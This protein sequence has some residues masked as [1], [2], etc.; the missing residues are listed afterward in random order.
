MASFSRTGIT[1]DT[2]YSGTVNA[3]VCGSAGGAWTLSGCELDC[4]QPTS[5]TGYNFS[6]A[7]TGSLAK[8]G[9]ARDGVTCATGYSG[10]VTETACTTGGQDYTVA[11]CDADCTQPSTG[12]YN[13]TNVAGSKAKNGF[14][15]TGITC[16]SGYSG[17][18]VAAVC[19]TGGNAYTVTGCTADTCKS[20]LAGY[21][22]SS[23]TGSIATGSFAVTGVQCASGYAGVPIATV[24]ASANAPYV[25]SGCVDTCVRPTTTG[26]DFS[27]VSETDLSADGTF[28]VTGITC[29]SGY[30]GTAVATVCSSS[31]KYVVSGCTVIPAT[32]TLRATTTGAPSTTTAAPV[33]ALAKTDA[34]SNITPN[35]LSIVVAFIAL[36]IM[37]N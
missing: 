16:A 27:S 35:M 8:T 37:H 31:D 7:D 15:I 28:D 18:A 14:S 25:L 24:C 9:F 29:A 22:L 6:T 21:D 1:C 30:Q 20:P 12:G 5:E 23:A 26:Y 2:G 17:T 32:T 3:T 36:Y 10:T 13:F 34:S 11:G 19:G 4:T 33:V